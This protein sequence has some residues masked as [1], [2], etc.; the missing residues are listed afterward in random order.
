[1]IDSNGALPTRSEDRI[2]LLDVLRGF[3]LFG[4]LFVNMTWFTGYAVIGA[5]E[6]AALG[7]QGIDSVTAFLIHVFVDSKFWSLFALLFGVGFAIQCRRAA[8]RDAAFAPYFSRRMIILLAIGLL[9][10]V[11]IWFGDIVSLY[12]AT[13]LVLLV[14]CRA[15]DRAV[16]RWAIIGLLLPVLVSAGWLAAELMSGPQDAPA[17]DPGHGP[18][19]LLVY[20]GGGTY[21]EV[22]SANWAFLKE[23]WFL[24][25]YEGRF[26]KLLGMFLLGVAM[27]RAG[28]FDDPSRHRPLLKNILRWGLIVGVPANIALAAFAGSVSLRPPTLAGWSVATISTVGI[29]ALCLAYAAGLTLLFQQDSWRRRLALFAPVGRMSLTNYVLQSVI[30]IAIFY[31]IGLGLWGRIGATWSVPVIALI[32]VTQAIISA[33]WLRRFTYGPLEWLWRSLSYG[34]SLPWRRRVVPNRDD[35]LADRVA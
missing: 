10:A 7:T 24:A 34:K 18:A 19:E 12:A 1:M 22:L 35:T 26:F 9:H 15:S 29:P 3:A 30:G 27:T 21:A 17:V 8:A 23:R 31:G 28:I 5:D 16:L 4:I 13:G 20:F 11:F 25:V 2:L 6:R 32:F 14:F 33:L